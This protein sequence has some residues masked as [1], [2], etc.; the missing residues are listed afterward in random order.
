MAVLD[1]ARLFRQMRNA[2]AR[3]RSVQIYARSGFHLAG[4]I[5]LLAEGIWQLFG[6]TK[7]MRYLPDW[8]SKTSLALFLVTESS[9]A[10]R[11]LDIPYQM[12]S[13]S[14]SEVA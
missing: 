4:T 8:I 14:L 11:K 1:D 7:G 3:G 2:R 13:R 9:A 5:I 6:T 10:C 12:R